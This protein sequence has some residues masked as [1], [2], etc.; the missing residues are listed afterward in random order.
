[1]LTSPAMPRFGNTSQWQNIA[2]KPATLMELASKAAQTNQEPYD[3]I[4]VQKKEV[5]VVRYPSPVND[6]V[7]SIG[8]VDAVVDA[9]N[10][11]LLGAMQHYWGGPRGYSVGS[12]QYELDEK[13][14]NPFNRL[15]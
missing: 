9:S 6:L 12:A 13:L 3:G 1:M 10:G 15:A 2:V 7:G 5:Y 11:D 14:S 4:Q 8:P